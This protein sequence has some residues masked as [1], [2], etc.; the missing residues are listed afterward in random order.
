MTELNIASGNFD[1]DNFY[2]MMPPDGA[3][4][5][6]GLYL[7]KRPSSAGWVEGSEGYVQ[8]T[9]L[10]ASI[11][12]FN[13]SAGFNDNSNSLNVSLIADEYNKSDGLP[14]GSGDDI[15][16]NGKS[17]CFAP[18]PIG[19][20]VFFKFGKNFASTHQAYA[21]SYEMIY[22][23]P[24]LATDEEILKELGS[25]TRTE[26]EAFYKEN[27][28]TEAG[29]TQSE[30]ECEFDQ[31]FQ[32]ESR[33]IKDHHYL[34][35][36]QSLS[37]GYNN[38]KPPQPDPD[39]TFIDKAK[40]YA[41]SL[42]GIDPETLDSGNHPAT[43]ARGKDHIVFGGILQGYSENKS[44]N[45]NPI[46]SVTVSDPKEI[47]SNCTLILNDY[48]QTTFNNKNLFNV[49]GF[50]EHELTDSL[51]GAIEAEAAK[52]NLLTKH[53]LYVEAE[54][55]SVND[56]INLEDCYLMK[57]QVEDPNLRSDLKP[58]ED[59]DS[60]TAA[61][62]EEGEEE[63][64]EEKESWYPK[65]GMRV[66]EVKKDSILD[67]SEVKYWF[68]VTGHG[69]S[70]RS[71]KGMPLYRILQALPFMNYT[72]PQEFA[73]NGYGGPIDFRGYKFALNIDGLQSLFLDESTIELME[74]D[75]FQETV[76]GQHENVKCPAKT[77]ADVLRDVYID[78]DDLTIL[79]LIQEIASIFNKD[80]IVELL[81]TIDQEKL[82]SFVFEE[83]DRINELF[84]ISKYNEGIL[85]NIQGEVE[86][87]ALNDPDVVDDDSETT[88]E[89]EEEP[90][91][92]GFGDQEISL[93][94]ESRYTENDLIT[95][96]I[97]VTFIDKNK[98]PTFDKISE[99]LKNNEYENAEIGYDLVNNV[100]D[101]FLVGAQKVDLYF[102]SS[103]R[104]RDSRLHVLNKSE[105][106]RG[107]LE[108]LEKNQWTFNESLKQQILPYY[109]ELADGV[110]SIP[111]GFGP[112]QQILLNSEG[113]NAFGVGEYY[114]ATE[115]ELRTAMISYEQW[116]KFISKYNRRY[117]ESFVAKSDDLE[118]FPAPSQEDLD[119]LKEF[120]KIDPDGDDDYP[121]VLDEALEEKLD[122]LRCGVV[123]PRSVIVSN[124]NWYESAIRSGSEIAALEIEAEGNSD[125]EEP[126]DEEA[127]AKIVIKDETR[128][129]S[130]CFPPYGYPVYY[131]R[132]DSIGVLD[133]SDVHRLITSAEA[134]QNVYFELPEIL[135]DYLEKGIRENLFNVESDDA[136]D[137]I[138]SDFLKKQRGDAIKQNPTQGKTREAIYKKYRDYKKVAKKFCD[139]ATASTRLRFAFED[140][141]KANGHIVAFVNNIIRLN[142]QNARK[143]H[144]FLKSIA[145]EHLGKSFLVKLPQK[146]NIRYSDTVETNQR[147]PNNGMVLESG[148]FGF[149]SIP[150]SGK[151]IP[152]AESEEFPINNYDFLYR[153]KEYS[154]N[155]LYDD[156]VLNPPVL[157]NELE[158]ESGYFIKSHLFDG[159]TTVQVGDPETPE[160]EESEEPE[161]PSDKPG[162][163]GLLKSTF[164][165]D[166]AFAF[167]S[168]SG[169]AAD[170]GSG[171]SFSGQLEDF[172]RKIQY[173][174]GAFKPT[175]NPISN[176]WDFNYL[177]QNKGGWFDFSISEEKSR[178]NMLYPIDASKLRTETNR[179]SAYAIFNHS[180]LLFFKNGDTKNIVQERVSQD[181]GE[182]DHKTLSR[183]KRMDAC[184]ILDNTGANLPQYE[185]NIENYKNGF[186]EFSTDKSFFGHEHVAYVK[187][188]V[189]EKLY[190]AP[191]FCT[192]KDIPVAAC[193]FEIVETKALANQTIEEEIVQEDEIIPT[194]VT[195]VELITTRILSHV[196]KPKEAEEE[197]KTFVNSIEFAD[198]KY[199]V[200]GSK[201][202]TF[203]GKS[204]VL[205]NKAVLN[206]EHVYALV[207]LSSRAVAAHDKRYE[208][209][210]LSSTNL[211]TVAR[212]LNRDTIKNGGPEG[213]LSDPPALNLEQEKER[214]RYL[215]KIEAGQENVELNEA[216]P[217]SNPE[218]MLNYMH[219]SPVIPNVIALPLLSKER[220]YGPWV[221]NVG[222]YKNADGKGTCNQTYRDIG[223]K[224]EFVKDENLSPWKFDGYE[225]M[226]QAAEIQITYSNSLMLFSE[227]GSFTT[228]G[229][230]KDV[231]IGRPLF[232]N[233]PVIDS[234]SLSVDANSIRTTVSLEVFS[235]KFGKTKKQKEEQLARLTREQKR[236][237]QNRNR[238]IRLDA[239][240][241]DKAKEFR[242]N[243]ELFGGLADGGLAEEL[244]SQQKMQTVYD[245]VVASV[246]PVKEESFVYK[247]SGVIYK[248]YPTKSGLVLEG[249]VLKTNNNASFQKKDYLNEI[250]SK[251][252]DVNELNNALQRTA[253]SL[254]ND[255]YFPFDE[256]VYNPYM[257][258]TP[259]VDAD[260]ITRR[261]S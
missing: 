214:I 252:T 66:G 135:R 129:A 184:T 239:E 159:L 73:D 180:E 158:P 219:P 143:V 241:P 221:S 98:Q 8:Q 65:V 7:Q 91:T 187:A 150:Q 1:P 100:T 253:G 106:V 183:L 29:S 69:M 242:Q 218:L 147:P 152:E 110:A 62:N 238:L 97:S 49:Y 217:L 202:K 107:D 120:L 244:T 168:S 209:T 125:Q 127:E 206:S 83:K 78:L 75:P 220:C 111:V 137:E 126:I 31:D 64:E 163:E 194:A 193:D 190:F 229:I 13:I 36:D 226:D 200:E 52:K 108:I 82:E 22:K 130:P 141:V 25:G 85:D 112:F 35:S 177:P 118:K 103:D 197:K 227:K 93:G 92:P 234:I 199:C 257:T 115:A 160:D 33:V 139:S 10:G 251:Y 149:N 67:Q 223:G 153:Q 5:G 80:F 156:V 76:Y 122:N 28:C 116:R 68:P 162:Y 2:G 59:E 140:I 205:Q 224:V 174:N 17:D 119:Y 196:Y 43:A 61:S 188:S 99:Y 245:S 142:D 57:N 169:S 18:P 105:D 134:V 128:P 155:F 248:D 54:A 95:S 117:V 21:K 211:P 47:L 94:K 189:D 34:K 88:D 4:Q 6:S 191:R 148:C 121:F 40:I 77:N 63:G 81:P 84:E 254:L 259:Y 236:N 250:K 204:L 124:A 44:A 213:N 51:R 113:L 9:F 260:A 167:P 48:S 133:P 181:K 237:R 144:T 230:P 37:L 233:S 109:G 146:T 102:F 175:Y 232:K 186:N 243:L 240:A 14:I 15:Y 178:D 192:Y 23:Y 26:M 89:D 145:D 58:P 50:L 71:D 208:E 56:Y 212:Y 123:V 11:V 30:E 90:P 19:A 207:K 12:N 157:V 216:L 45:G 46:Y 255:I 131:G 55:E 179:I 256:S 3:F 72:M 16:H 261:T 70:R 132:G 38:S 198:H 27:S 225:N 42:L 161:S 222:L 87:T 210:A 165:Y 151:T 101:K 79:E 96:I 201:K 104:D 20:P 138:L 185:K 173:S 235:S 215:T 164:K 60:E 154:E 171:V 258:S 182:E 170:L 32:E 195:G 172:E 53:D 228:P 166:P 231:Y 203:I 74:E 86:K 249:T 176:S 39:T 136:C 24:L 246:V 247:P 114:L 41:P